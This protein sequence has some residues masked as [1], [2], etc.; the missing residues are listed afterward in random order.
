L[1][2]QGFKPLPEYHSLLQSTFQ[3]DIRELDFVK[4]R[5]DSA[6]QVHTYALQRE[7]RRV[8]ELTSRDFHTGFHVFGLYCRMEINNTDRDFIGRPS[9]AD[10][11]YMGLPLTRGV[12]KRRRLSWL[13][14]RALV[15]EPKCGGRGEGG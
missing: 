9:A 6:N 15:Y 13:T 4:N 14:N 3:S 5:K 8:N 1:F 2:V 7:E 10:A 12:T 11:E